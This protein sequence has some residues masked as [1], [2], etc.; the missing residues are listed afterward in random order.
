MGGHLY[1]SCAVW[2]VQY[3]GF[4]QYQLDVATTWA[5]QILSEEA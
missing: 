4:T 2:V 3:G 5:L 1:W